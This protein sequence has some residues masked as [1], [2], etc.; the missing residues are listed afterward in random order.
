MLKTFGIYKL[1]SAIIP[2][3]GLALLSTIIE[4]K[5]ENKINCKITVVLSS[6]FAQNGTYRVAVFNSPDGFPKDLTKAILKIS[7]KAVGP[8]T[9]MEITGLKPGN[10]AISAFLDQD[11]N[12]KMNKLFGLP[13]E[14]FGFSNFQKQ[15]IPSFD[16]SKLMVIDSL[17][18]TITIKRL[19]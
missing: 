18:D 8:Y 15:S 5:A 17:T 11:D 1:I 4:L 14:P 9:K 10:Y 16:E 6:K 7:S 12:G 19:F 13:T 3:L 2:V